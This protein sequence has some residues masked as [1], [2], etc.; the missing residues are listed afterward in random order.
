M[1]RWNVISDIVN[2]NN[3]KIGAEIG[4][5]YG[6]NIFNVLDLCP[7]LIMIGIDMWKPVDNVSD[8]GPK[9]LYGYPKMNHSENEKKVMA[10]AVKYGD[11]L[12]ILK[13]ESTE[14]AKLFDDASSDFVFID[15]CHAQEEVGLDINAWSKKVRSGGAIMG[16]D[17]HFPSV[18]NAVIN[19]LGKYETLPDNC[20]C[21]Y[22]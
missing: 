2:T 4:V 6:L 1:D 19:T 16:H 10:G 13:Q 12:K 20:W 11:R 7:D 15:A 22:A 8:S 3:Y 14:A 21:V 9:G 17:I 18:A 5:C